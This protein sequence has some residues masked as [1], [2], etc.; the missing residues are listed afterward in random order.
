MIVAVDHLDLR[1]A[2]TLHVVD[3]H[4]QG[5]SPP[6]IASVGTLLALSALGDR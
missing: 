2:I 4:F 3:A 6:M 1:F 5:S